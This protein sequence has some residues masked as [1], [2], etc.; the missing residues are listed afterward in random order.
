MTGLSKTPGSGA[1][2]VRVCTFV[3][4]LKEFSSLLTGNGTFLNVEDDFR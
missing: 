3:D 1:D 2:D 4:C